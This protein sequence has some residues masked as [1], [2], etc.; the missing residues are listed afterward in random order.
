MKVEIKDINE[1]RKQ[2]LVEVSGD[3]VSRVEKK[4]LKEFL[5]QAN[6][7]G[8]RKG[9]A[10]EHLLRA[11]FG[12][13]IDAELSKRL[14]GSAF[15]EA[16]KESKLEV[17]NV[18]NFEGNDFSAG[19]DSE[20]KITIDSKPSVSVP[21]VSDVELETGSTDVTDDEVEQTI[22]RLL[23]DRAS[24]EKVERSAQA[25]DYVKCSYEGRVGDQMVAE[26]APDQ[27][28][29]GK[30]SSTWEEAGEPQEGVPSVEAVIRGLVG[31]Q[32]GDEKDVEHEFA[33]DF[34]IEA[35]AGK[36][37]SYHITVEEV[38]ERILPEM[39]EAFFQGFG[40]KD[41]DELA[42]G[43]RTN[44]EQ[45]KKDQVQADHRQQLGKALQERADFPIPES[46]HEQ[47]TQAILQDLVN[48]N[49]QQGISE[50]Q[51]E[52]HKEQLH[53]AAED[54]AR[55]RIKLR[56]ILLQHAKDKKLEVED[57]EIHATVFQE[58]Q[59][60]QVPVEDLAK[61][62]KKD[63]GSIQNI[64][65]DILAEKSLHSILHDIKGEDCCDGHEHGDHSHDDGDH[66]HDHGEDEAKD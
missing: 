46:I 45:Q 61:E 43:V 26:L 58:A 19:V 33:G 56:Y 55:N 5:Q 4:I 12:K 42:T 36:Q 25:G 44:L 49:F 50:D 16:V 22:K 28:L 53:A 66:S 39:D 51:L 37:A 30:Q 48:T 20:V 40:V 41:K 35:L 1:T 38:R 21:D 29:L 11:K 47:E 14:S 64:R 32:A 3:E 57:R 6:L 9:K 65:D 15:Q 2:L 62:L 8:F 34:A 24:F 23:T 27:P 10:P 60:R 18:L 7:K 63:P 54:S 17:V 59:R 13:D 52:E 31:M